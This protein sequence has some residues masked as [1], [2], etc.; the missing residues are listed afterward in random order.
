ME[1]KLALRIKRT[2]T[3]IAE[4]KFL[5]QESKNLIEASRQMTEE[6]FTACI[7]FH[8]S[9]GSNPPKPY[10]CLMDSMIVLREYAP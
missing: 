8:R 3:L 1:Q 7:T 5:I 10:K 6:S 4:S 9:S 2:E